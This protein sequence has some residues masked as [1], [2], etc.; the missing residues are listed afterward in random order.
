MSLSL[1]IRCGTQRDR[2]IARCTKCG[3]APT[4]DEDKAKS[5]LLSLDCEIDG[6]YRGRTKEELLALSTSF[7]AGGA[8]FEQRDLDAVLAHARSGSAISS[9]KLL[10]D[11]VRWVGLPLLALVLVFLL[12]HF[13]E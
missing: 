3:F 2:P 10:A 8:T 9:R 1:C 4:T 6:E 5:L 13:T 7:P 11:L 12:L